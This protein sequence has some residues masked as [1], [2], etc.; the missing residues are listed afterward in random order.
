MLMGRDMRIVVF[1]VDDT[2]R[3][4]NLALTVTECQS[5]YPR[6]VGGVEYGDRVSHRDY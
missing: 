1:L 6:L 5:L 3:S 4:L 2:Y